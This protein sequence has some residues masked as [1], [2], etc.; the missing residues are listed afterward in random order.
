MNTPEVVVFRGGVSR[1][2]EVSLGSGAA[3]LAALGRSHRVRD[4]IIEGRCLP[5]DFD[6]RSQVVFSTLHGVFG[7][8]GEMQ[9]LL[10][11]AGAAFT[12]CDAAASRLCFDKQATRM[13]AAEAGVAIAPG[14]SFESATA[15]GPD[16]LIAQVG[17]DCVFKP[18]CEGSSVGLRFARGA[19]EIREALATLAPGSWMCEQRIRGRELTVGWLDGNPL[20]VVEIRPQSGQFDYR[21]KYTKGLTEYLSPAPLSAELTE[22]TR[23]AAQRACIACG[24]RDFARADFILREDGIPV[25][26]EINTLPGLKETSLLPM[27][28]A[29]FGLSFTDL[30]NAMLLPALKRFHSTHPATVHA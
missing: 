9:A 21:S 24:C 15:P 5:P 12:G 27:S 2:R 1:E 20:G 26:L 8:D 23:A 16:A 30:V 17:E 13:R 25:L 14:F 19:Q 18:R 11:Q 6:P 29:Q 22:A 10:E 28:A 7:E 4:C 3:A